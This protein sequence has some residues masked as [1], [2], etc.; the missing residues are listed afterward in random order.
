M[1]ERDDSVAALVALRERERS[2]TVTLLC[3]EADEA[4]CHRTLLKALVEGASPAA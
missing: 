2:E 3:W 4:N 1:A